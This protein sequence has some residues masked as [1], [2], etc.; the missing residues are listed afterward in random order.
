MSKR[1]GE[2]G[3]SMAEILG[4]LAIVGVLSIGGIIGLRMAFDKNETNEIV[5]ELTQRAVLLSSMKSKEMPANLNEFQNE[6]FTE[7]YNVSFNDTD[8]DGF[9]TITLENV[10]DEVVEELKKMEWGLPYNIYVNENHI[11]DHNSQLTNQRVS[12]LF[13]KSAMADAGGNTVTFVFQN[14]LNENVKPDYIDKDE[15]AQTQGRWNGYRC[16]CPKGAAMSAEGCILKPT[17]DELK[18]AI[19]FLDEECQ[20]CLDICQNGKCVQDKAAKCNGERYCDGDKIKT[21]TASGYKNNDGCVTNRDEVEDCAKDDNTMTC[22]EIN[23]KAQCVKKELSCG[24]NG[25]WNPQTRMCDC[26]E[27][28]AGTV[29]DEKD[30]GYFAC[31]GYS[32]S[33]RADGSGDVQLN[34]DIKIEEFDISDCQCNEYGTSIDPTD[35]ICNSQC[36]R[37]M[38]PEGYYVDGVCCA[39]KN[40]DK[41]LCCAH[42]PEGKC[43]TTGDMTPLD[44]FC[45]TWFKEQ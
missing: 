24:E 16:V 1:R 6:A 12:S 27:G 45:S 8:I 4:V 5:H 3:R 25:H 22:A 17:P 20:I 23:G 30:K 35:E 13:V 10:P 29:C 15:C 7:K 32:S 19:C 44:S 39:D 18:N 36:C 28:Y 41:C 34:T 11:Y 2:F 9:F 42:C 14:Q 33:E 43:K 37:K 31:L 21:C 38:Y 26:D 40:N